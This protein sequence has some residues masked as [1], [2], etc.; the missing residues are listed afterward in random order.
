MPFRVAVSYRVILCRATL[1]KVY[2][3]TTERTYM[4]A[5]IETEEKQNNK[6]KK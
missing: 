4:K 3:D 2:Q 5:L 6:S 1:S